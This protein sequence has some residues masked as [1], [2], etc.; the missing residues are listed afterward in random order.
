[1]RCPPVPVL[2]VARA[3]ELETLHN[4]PLGLSTG[5]VRCRGKESGGKIGGLEKKMIERVGGGRV[6]SEEGRET[7][8]RER[9]LG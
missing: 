5:G 3:C 4:G 9:L 7:R 8:R 2:E 6:R 1:M